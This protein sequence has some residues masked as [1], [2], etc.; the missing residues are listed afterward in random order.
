MFTD[1]RVKLFSLEAPSSYKFMMK[2]SKLE[3]VKLR[4]IIVIIWN[5]TNV[6]YNMYVRTRE[7]L[8]DIYRAS[9]CV[10]VLR[11]VQFHL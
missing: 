8:V 4:Y 2:L 5:T 9:F 6:K 1:G 10:V 7:T 11:S 3:S